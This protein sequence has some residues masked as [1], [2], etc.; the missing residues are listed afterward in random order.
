[1]DIY[2]QSSKQ[3]DRWQRLA[4][5][6]GIPKMISHVSS[7]RKKSILIDI[8]HIA[9]INT[10]KEFDLLLNEAYTWGKDFINKNYKEISYDS[11][12]YLCSDPYCIISL[13]VIILRERKS[14]W[15]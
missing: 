1:L 7:E 3:R 6:A 15:K 8:L 2:L 12:N 14:H 5:E 10:L 11:G 9:K 4:E 13:I